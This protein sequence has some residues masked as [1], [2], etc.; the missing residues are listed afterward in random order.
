VTRVWKER[1]AA[2][3]A[4]VLVSSTVSAEQG[5]S[6]GSIEGVVIARD[7]GTPVAGATVRVSGEAGQYAAVT[8]RG[9]RFHFDVIPAGRVTL[10][11]GA[12]GFTELRVPDVVVLGNA[13]TS[14]TFSLPLPLNVLERVQVTASKMPETVGDLGAQASLVSREA[15]DARGDQTLPQAIAHVPGAVLSTQLGIFD[16]VM[17]RGLPRGDPEFTNTLLLVDGVPQTLSNNGA[18][19]AALPINDASGIEIIRGPNSALYGR[20]APARGRR[21]SDWRPIRRAQDG[22][23]RFRAGEALGRLLRL[24]GT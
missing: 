2:V 14:V 15:I 24:G 20:T 7:G 1:V 9:G 3:L 21:R 5:A 22:R 19:I 6:A 17:L 12:A 10:T 16:S 8:D 11:A 18:R 13:A 4:A 23:A